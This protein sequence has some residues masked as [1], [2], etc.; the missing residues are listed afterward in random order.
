MYEFLPGVKM[1]IIEMM[2]HWKIRLSYGAKRKVGE[3]RFENGI[4]QR[5]AFS[6]LL[7]VLM[8]D[9]LI[10]ILKRV[11]G[12]DVEVLNYMVDLKASSASIEKAVQVHETVKNYALSVGMVI[13][14]KKSAIQLSVEAPLPQS[15]QYI[16]R[17][18]E[19]TNKYLE[20]EMKRCAVDT[21]ETMKVLE[22]LIQ[23]KLEEPRRRVGVF[24]ARNWI[25]FINQNV[26]S[27]VRFF[28]RPDKFT[29][30]WLER[31]DRM[32]LQHLTQQGKLMKRAWR[33]AG[34]T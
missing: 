29:L 31:L 14:A 25:Q 2:A 30:R 6:P 1:L 24:E 7:F 5:D 16:P 15:L 22:Q 9:P 12:D 21:K 32:I 13:N 4:I 23:E 20:F 8:I 3:V 28:S 17:L 18:D 34:S 19:T 10:K 33:Q 26:M 11:G 27:V